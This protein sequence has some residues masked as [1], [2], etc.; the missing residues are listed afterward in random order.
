MKA[1][2]WSDDFMTDYTSGMAFA[3][4]ETVEEARKML[5]KQLTNDGYPSGIKDINKNEP[6]MVLD[7]PCSE[8]ISGGS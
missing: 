6:D 7:L 4:A 2:I 3:I 1:F 8:Y 5:C